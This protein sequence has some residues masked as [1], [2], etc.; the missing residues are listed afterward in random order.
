MAIQDGQPV[1][2]QNS[3]AAFVSKTVNSDIIS[4]PSLKNNDVGSGAHVVNPQKAINKAFEGVGTTG[5]N[6]AN[7]NNYA[8]NNFISDGDSRKTAIEKLDLAIKNVADNLDDVGNNVEQFAIGG[9]I[10]VKL[11]SGIV[12]DFE[13]LYETTNLINGELEIE[14][15]SEV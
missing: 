11:T 13:Q 3:N 2:A 8:N 9:L 10:E 4:I 1:D 14:N 5:E 15:L 7:I 12:V 6:D